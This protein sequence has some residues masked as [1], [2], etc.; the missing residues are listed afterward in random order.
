M[1]DQ[2]RPSALP[3]QNNGRQRTE[4]TLVVPE[5]DAKQGRKGAHVFTILMVS[6]VLLIMAAG[7]LLAWQQLALRDDPSR[8]TIRSQTQPPAANAPPPPSQVSPSTQ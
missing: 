7:I 5:T 3:A 8:G 1:T 4:P 6:L 2:N